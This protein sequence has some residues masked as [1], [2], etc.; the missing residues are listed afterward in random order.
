MT[1]TITED[2]ADDALFKD[3]FAEIALKYQE[4]ERAGIEKKFEAEIVSVTGRRISHY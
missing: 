3:E 4:A 1:L 2:T